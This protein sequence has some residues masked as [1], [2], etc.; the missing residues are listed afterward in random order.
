MSTPDRPQVW[1]FA[2][3]VRGGFE[4]QVILVSERCLLRRD[5]SGHIKTPKSGYCERTMDGRNS[6]GLLPG[7]GSIRLGFASAGFKKDHPRVQARQHSVG[8]DK[9]RRENDRTP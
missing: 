4:H 6:L 7:Y 3:V 9:G 1:V 8:P 5:H 2:A